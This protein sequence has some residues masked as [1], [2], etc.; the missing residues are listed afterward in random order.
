MIAV[1]LA[2]EAVSLVA[3]YRAAT[4]YLR[5]HDPR[6]GGSASEAVALAR[7]RLLGL[8][9]HIAPA[10]IT[11][12]LRR[13]G[14][15][16]REGAGA[17]TY[18]LDGNRLHI[19]ARLPEFQSAIISFRGRRIEAITIEGRQVERV[20]IEPSP[21]VSFIRM[22]R[23]D[24]A[25]RMRARRIALRPDD[26]IPSALYDAV[27]A[28]E[29]H[30][31]ASHN[32]IDEIGLIKGLFAGRGGSTIT[33]QMIKNVVLAD[34]SRT[35]RRKA[36]EMML[37]LAAERMLTKEEIFAAYANNCYLGH[38]EGGPTIIGFA[39]AAQELFGK[40]DVK[41]LTLA[42]SAALA[43]LLNQPE[44]YLR[45]ARDGDYR[46]AAARRDRVLDLMRDKFSDLYT[47]EAI[48]EAKREPLTFLFA[49]ERERPL[50]MI[51]K[52][53]Q[54]YAAERV[55]QVTG[56]GGSLRIYTTMDE[57]LQSAAA[58]SVERH[59][60]KLD[61]KVES[62]RRGRGLGEGRL[63]AA[64]VAMD[65]RTGEILAMTGGRG[66][67]FNRAL[68]RRSP[69][70]AIKPFVYL[71]AVERGWHDGP[72]TAA[73]IIDPQSDRVDNY[74][75]TRQ[76]GASRRVRRH[77]A[78]SDNGA[79]VVAAHDAGLAEVR[80]FIHRLTG[81]YSEELT[82]MLAIGGSRGCEVSPLDLASAY[83]IFPNRGVKVSATPFAA[84]YRNGVRVNLP[85]AEPERMISPQAAFILTSMM[86][87]VVGRGADG[88]EGTAR[89]LA[90]SMGDYDIAGKTGTGEVSDFWFVG[91]TPRMVVA[92][93]VGMDDNMPLAL[94]EGFDAA[95]VAMP[96]W[97]EFM[98]AVKAS[99][100]DLLEGRF[101]MPS[102]VRVLRI[103]PVKGCVTKTGG[104]EE[105]FIAG[106][107][108]HGCEEVKR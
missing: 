49:S 107:E 44:A 6:A 17:G 29:D 89:S 45:A 66:G 43:G 31:F 72:F 81:S 2:F 20:E 75:P 61:S 28:S 13:L 3:A 87:S 90:V 35:V 24:V 33:Q 10:A 12:H 32:G 93:W 71:K 106:R 82:G 15:K 86:R 19:R 5:E 102:G 39:A 1:L 92:V 63:E 91:L 4:L 55:A 8:R 80:D 26:L 7:P 57:D 23:G 88:R 104:I 21:M 51:S 50:D 69:A 56:D 83:T 38:V 58:A 73:T 76:V 70:S 18:H 78:A 108:P 101:V 94:G 103:D 85:R 67:E 105:Y 98:R 22:V 54:I 30:R 97:A 16:S 36:Q 79:A 37:A 14:Y 68:A 84:V 95:R 77:L 100:P 27:R 42:E 64:L 40:T 53:F 74:R 59:L 47:A 99:R 60:S 65:A 9:Q 46:L 25:S 48:D 62:I 52:P 96:V 34:Q 11:D 41:S